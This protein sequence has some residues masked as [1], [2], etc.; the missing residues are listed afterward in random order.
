MWILECIILIQRGIFVQI[1]FGYSLLWK[2]LNFK[3]LI[4]NLVITVVIIF[5]QF[6]IIIK[7][8]NIILIAFILI[9]ITLLIIYGIG[10]KDKVGIIT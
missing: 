2:I 1:I 8:L 3:H 4:I 9:M 5:I 7:N 6:Y 10:I